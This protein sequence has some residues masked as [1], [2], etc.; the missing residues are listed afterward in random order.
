MILSKFNG[1][2]AGSSTNL[3]ILA[4]QEFQNLSNFTLENTQYGMISFNGTVN[5]SAHGSSIYFSDFDRYI[6]ISSNS[7]SLDSSVL[8]NLNISTIL[9]L[10]GLTFTNPRILLDGQECSS[11]ICTKE[12]Y[13]GGILVF[14]VTH[15]TTYS[16]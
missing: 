14:N 8:G 16:T 9:R 3:C 2:S 12:S 10:Y 15:F 4:F 6:E 5:L 13:S 7:I 1:S 11:T